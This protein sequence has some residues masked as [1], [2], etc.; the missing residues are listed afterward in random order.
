M[1]FLVALVGHAIVLHLMS[2]YAV[3]NTS[4]L[5]VRCVALEPSTR[6]SSDGALSPDRLNG[7]RVA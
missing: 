7:R 1:Q 2:Y 4:K 6:S 5:D 3:Y